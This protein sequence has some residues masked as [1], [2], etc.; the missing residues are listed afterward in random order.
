MVD[1]MKKSSKNYIIAGVIFLAVILITLYIFKWYNVVNEE[2][3]SKSYLISNGIITNEINS[4]DELEA[5]FSESPSEYFLYIS[6][7]NNQKIYD[8]EID[9]KKVI[10]KYNL[11]DKFYYLNVDTIK[12]DNDFLDKLNNALGLTEKKVT[13]IPTILYF[14]DHQLVDEKILL[15]NNSSIKIDD[16]K[17]FLEKLEV[18][19]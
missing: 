10:N 3:I 12:E 16:L 9:L 14:K 4:I 2:K 6:Y 19:N 11:Q 7:T 17:K 15:T 1:K 8:M 13:T 5:V 18:S